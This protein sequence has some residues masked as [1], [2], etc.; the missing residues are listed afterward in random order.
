MGPVHALEW[1]HDHGCPCYN[2]AVSNAIQN[3]HIEVVKYLVEH[4]RAFSDKACH[5]AAIVGDVAI[6]HFLRSVHCQW[7]HLV[8]VY[9]AG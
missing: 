3:Q 6:L 8:P 4:G 5:F 2:S 1:L 9:A 7:D